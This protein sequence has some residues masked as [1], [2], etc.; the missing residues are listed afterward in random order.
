MHM[1]T[2]LVPLLLLLVTQLVNTP[3]V[4]EL[5][6]TLTHQKTS[7][8]LHADEA[9]ALTLQKPSWGRPG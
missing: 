9:G 3:F 5:P 7:T 4:Q 8:K 2:G 1:H 6:T